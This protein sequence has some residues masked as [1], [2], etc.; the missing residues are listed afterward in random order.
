MAELIQLI[1]GLTKTTTTLEHI[2]LVVR[3]CK[4]YGTVQGGGFIGSAVVKLLCIFVGG[5][6]CGINDE[7]DEVGWLVVVVVAMVAESLD[8]CI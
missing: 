3:D 4:Q 6:V 8:I 7:D 2:M 5:F 1:D